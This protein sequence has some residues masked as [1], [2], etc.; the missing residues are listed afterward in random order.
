MRMST[1]QPSIFESATV[2]HE[3]NRDEHETY[4]KQLNCAKPFF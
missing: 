1:S 3:K 2:E 4:P